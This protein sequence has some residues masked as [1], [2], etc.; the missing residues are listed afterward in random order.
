MT[1][2]ISEYLFI[3]LRNS[4]M[5]VGKFPL[6]QV[7]TRSSKVVLFEVI[8]RKILSVIVLSQGINKRLVAILNLP[9][10]KNT[11]LSLIDKRFLCELNGFLERKKRLTCS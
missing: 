8:Q 4:S 9:K 10:T 7:I 11:K 1:R 5:P 6:V 3:F 2:R